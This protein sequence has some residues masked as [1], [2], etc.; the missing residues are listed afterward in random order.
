MVSS[1]ITRAHVLMNQQFSSRDYNER[2]ACILSEGLSSSRFHLRA[3]DELK[4]EC[5]VTIKYVINYESSRNIHTE[6]DS[7]LFLH[8]M[9]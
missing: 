3:T 9:K 1:V 8:S 6:L 5:F 2:E 7:A 4:T